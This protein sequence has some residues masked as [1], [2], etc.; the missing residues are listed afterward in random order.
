MSVHVS[1]A[2]WLNERIRG[3]SKLVLLKLADCADDDGRNAYPSVA[4][5]ARECGIG[6]RSVQRI[7]G[8]L[9]N[10][11][12]L[13]VTREASAIIHRPTTY[14]VLPGAKMTPGAKRMSEMAPDPSVSDLD[15]DQEFLDSEGSDQDGW[16]AT[17]AREWHPVSDR[18]HGEIER[19][20]RR[21]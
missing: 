6:E 13:V 11:G 9:I 8:G 2:V 7:L 18:D 15:P 16:G 20:I 4:R 1:S 12:Y 17:S 21:R 10:A 5:I 3:T 19:V 14:R